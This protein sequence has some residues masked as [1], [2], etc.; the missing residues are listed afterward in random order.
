[1]ARAKGLNAAMTKSQMFSEIAEN[2]ELSKR[3]VASVFDALETVIE[4]HVKKGSVGYCTVPGLMKIKTVQKPAQP[5]RGERP[6]PVSA[7]GVHGCEG[8]ARQHTREDP[9]PQEAQGHGVA[10]SSSI[11]AQDSG[12]GGSVRVY[13]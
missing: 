10:R 2:T 7:R 4:R 13:G 12:L 9:C 11:Q 6:E 5:A 1:M 3:A 8:K